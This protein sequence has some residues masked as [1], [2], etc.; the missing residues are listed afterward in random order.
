VAKRTTKHELL[1]LTKKA[2]ELA[3]KRV[4]KEEEEEEEV[5][6]DDD[7]PAWAKALLKSNEN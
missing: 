2:E 5:K 6:I 4:V 3:A 1:K 7:A